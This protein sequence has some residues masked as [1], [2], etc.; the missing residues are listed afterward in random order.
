M[1]ADAPL[2][3]A[4]VGPRSRRPA[5]RDP[6]SA[7]DEAR[8]HRVGMAR[9]LVG[10]DTLPVA[11]P[12]FGLELL[13]VVAAGPAIDLVLGAAGTALARVR[14]SPAEAGDG[15]LA[16]T[17]ETQPGAV[18]FRGA[19]ALIRERVGRALTTEKWSAARAHARAIAALPVG[20]PL[21]HFRQVIEGIHPPSGLVRTG[22]RCNQ[23]CGFCWQSRDW[24]GYGP[25]Q[26]RTW[27]EDLAEAGVVDLSISGGEPTLDRALVEHVRHARSLGMRSVVIETNAIQIGKRPA[28]AS[29]L[30]D[31]GLT[32]AFVSFHS[33][34]AEASDRATRAPGTH[35]RTVQGIRALLDAKVHVILNAVILKD[36]VAALPALPAFVR[37]HFAGS[38]WF[39]GVSIST[40]VLPYEHALAPTILADPDDVRR[41]LAATLDEA[42]KHR[43]RI[44]GID[45]PCGPPLCAFG[46]DRRVTDLAPK[47][48]VSFRVH[49]DE[50]A[51]CR[52]RLACYGVQRDDYARFGS[53]AVL[54]LA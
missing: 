7:D 4:S 27:I 17:R 14:L 33:P 46:A 31:A 26:V 10:A 22:F 20:V 52:V 2:D 3:G 43:V 37:E 1:N 44:F 19:L 29:E 34:E 53:R 41:A 18:R 25:E 30:H 23:D 12:R 28:L 32:R 16:T 9:A 45:G 47:P 42:E 48:S 38:G 21:S 49:V 51:S 6:P 15:Y 11:L 40:P 8:T 13:D 5:F 54:P 36:T 50:C 24:P 39:G 35:A